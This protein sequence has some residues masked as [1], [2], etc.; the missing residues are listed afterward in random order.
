[1]ALQRTVV[2]SAT[3]NSATTTDLIT[4]TD[5]TFERIYILWMGVD[6]QTAG[7]NWV[8]DIKDSGASPIRV[9]TFNA[10]AVGHLE[11]FPEL[12]FKDFPGVPLTV[13]KKLQC[14]S[15]GT[16]GASTI[17]IIYEIKGGA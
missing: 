2:T 4:P 16:P 11:C 9:G 6:T 13:G 17:T 7:T 1:M 3:I 8:L 12:G 14:V 5:T 15:T 10:S